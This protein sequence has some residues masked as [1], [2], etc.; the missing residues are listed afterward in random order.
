MLASGKLG[1]APY[2]KANLTDFMKPIASASVWIFRPATTQESA[3]RNARA[4]CAVGRSRGA[5][6]LQL[7]SR[8]GAQCPCPCAKARTKLGGLGT[9]TPVARSY[10]F[11]GCSVESVP[12]VSTNQRVEKGLL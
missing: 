9:P 12:K 6:R 8:G 3:T 10:P 11:C 1:V 5:A 7:P 2:R 4:R